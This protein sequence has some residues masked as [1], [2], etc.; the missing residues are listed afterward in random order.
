LDPAQNGVNKVVEQVKT[1]GYICWWCIKA[2]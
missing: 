1:S 2:L